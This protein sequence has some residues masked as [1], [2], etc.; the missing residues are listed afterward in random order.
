M[1]KLI[2]HNSQFEGPI[3]QHLLS[4][5]RK[6]MGAVYRVTSPTYCNS[7]VNMSYSW[8]NRDSLC[9]VLETLTS[10]CVHIASIPLCNHIFL[11][12]PTSRTLLVLR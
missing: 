1:I 7:L 2:H 10:D 6:E 3:F 12:G 9:V 11:C 5:I 4:R 8:Q